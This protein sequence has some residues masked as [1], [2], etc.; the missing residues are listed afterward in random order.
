MASH[1][2][3]SL[4]EFASVNFPPTDE[5]PVLAI[6]HSSSNCCE[7]ELITARYMPEFRPLNPWVDINGDA[8]TDSG[9][10]V[11]GWRNAFRWL[12]PR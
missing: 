5:R 11:I 6:R 7:Y 10:P 3:A 8:I 2:P 9:Q 1:L 12:Q 4:S